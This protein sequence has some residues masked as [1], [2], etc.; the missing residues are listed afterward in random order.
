M[1][2][3][4]VAV[5]QQLHHVVQQGGRLEAS[6]GAHCLRPYGR[7][8]VL[9]ALGQQRLRGRRELAGVLGGDDPPRQRRLGGLERGPELFSLRSRLREGGVHIERDGQEEGD[10]T[11]TTMRHAPLSVPQVHGRTASLR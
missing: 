8:G 1:T 6:R 7:V 2:H 4:G 10:G 3:R 5:G 9:H 11:R